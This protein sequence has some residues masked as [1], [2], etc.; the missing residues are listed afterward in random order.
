MAFVTT[1]SARQ[2]R[3]EAVRRERRTEP[4]TAVVEGSFRDLAE[5]FAVLHH[6]AVSLSRRLART[7]RELIRARRSLDGNSL[8]LIEHQFRWLSSAL[9]RLA[10]ESRELQ[11]DAGRGPRSSALLAGF[12]GRKRAIADHIRT[13]QGMSAAAITASEWQSPSFGHS[14]FPSAGRQIGEV[15]PHVDDYRRDRHPQAMEFEE[16]YLREY[17][18]DPHGIGLRA[19][20]TSSGMSAFVTILHH[21]AAQSGRGSVLMGRGVYHECRDLLASSPFAP[22]IVEVREDSA[23]DLLDAMERER[24]SIVVL[25]TMCNARGMALPDVSALIGRMRELRSDAYLILDNTGLSCTFQP[26]ALLEPDDPFP[27]ICFESL[28][29]YAQFGLDRTA[30][31]VIVARAGLIASLDPLREHLGANVPDALV[32]AVPEP[33]RAMLERRLLR[34]GRNAGLLAKALHECVKRHGGGVVAGVSYPGLETHP[35]FAAAEPLTFRGGYLEIRFAEAFDRPE[36][37]DRFVHRAVELAREARVPLTLGAGFGFD[38]TRVYH[39]A[40]TSEAGRSFVRIA[41]GT[42][43]LQQLADL[44]DVLARVLRKTAEDEPS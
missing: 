28:T 8:D 23:A 6:L 35:S 36:V 41:A 32:Y 5:D 44:A 19:L 3:E 13:L 18:D 27:V 29:K 42:E 26:Y 1:R 4:E 10:R 30:A 33:D 16:A 9:D 40:F 21:L 43:H 17:I 38:T 37:H 20:M 7:D 31:G 2:R 12:A 39:T 15:K 25:D 24:P 14:V 22:R 34:I 11:T